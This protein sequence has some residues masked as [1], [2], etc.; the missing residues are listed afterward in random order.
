M[1]QRTALHTEDGSAYGSHCVRL[2]PSGGGTAYSS[3]RRWH[4][5][6]LTQKVALR[7]AYTA[8]GSHR[9]WYCVRLTHKVALRTAH[10]QGGTAYGSH[11][12]WHCVRL[13]LRTA[14]TE[15]GT[16]YGS[17]CVRL[18]QKVALR[19]AHTE[20]GTAYGSHC[21]RL[22]HKVAL[23]TAQ[24]AYGS[25]RLGVALRTAHTAAYGSRRLRVALRISHTESGS[26]YISHRGWQCVRLTPECGTAYGPPPPPPPTHTHTLPQTEQI[27][28]FSGSHVGLLLLGRHFL[29]AD[30]QQFGYC[31]VVLVGVLL[32]ELGAMLYRVSNEPILR[33]FGFIRWSVKSQYINK[34]KFKKWRRMVMWI[35]MYKGLGAT[36]LVG[37]NYPSLNSFLRVCVCV[38]CARNTM[39]W[40]YN[41]LF[42][43]F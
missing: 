2:T 39:L 22:T 21:V 10:T 4:C 18:T 28:K 19:T 14:H 36:A 31:A 5:V 27:N 6:R 41:L 20:G 12:R 42:L 25:H 13:T 11:T 23:R 37:D 3:D 9:R 30:S 32:Q 29:P 15:G 33:A 7:T 17:H 16:A 1:A 34:I 35:Y 40:L 24:T 43:R 38:W 8:Y 26:A